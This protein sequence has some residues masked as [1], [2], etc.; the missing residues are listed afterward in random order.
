MELVRTGQ[1]TYGGA[2]ILSFRKVSPSKKS[3]I[4]AGEIVEEFEKYGHI[5]FRVP[6]FFYKAQASIIANKLIDVYAGRLINSQKFPK[7]QLAHRESF[8]INSATNT[9]ILYLERVYQQIMGELLSLLSVNNGNSPK[10]RLQLNIHYLKDKRH[11]LLLALLHNDKKVLSAIPAGVIT[12]PGHSSFRTL[13]GLVFVN[14][15]GQEIM[16]YPSQ[17]MKNLRYIIVTP[18]DKSLDII[19]MRH[20]VSLT[21]QQ[22]QSIGRLAWID[23]QGFLRGVIPCFK[24]I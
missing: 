13:G 23:N 10:D 4:T 22:I 24:N 21:V 16:P 7:E 3:V 17:L 2:K 5:G 20:S 15:N 8:L 9:G 18:Q 1:T 19:P 6:R 12:M 11:D 14:S